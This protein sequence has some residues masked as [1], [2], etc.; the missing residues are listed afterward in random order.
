MRQGYQCAGDACRYADQGPHR[1]VDC[2]AWRQDDWGTY[3]RAM[4]ARRRAALIAR[5]KD[6]QTVSV[7]R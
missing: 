4:D 6:R 1:A 7:Y 3:Q 2:L 5:G